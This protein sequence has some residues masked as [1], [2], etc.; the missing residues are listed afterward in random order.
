MSTIYSSSY[1]KALGQYQNLNESRIL[2]ERNNMQTSFD[3]LL[4]H[5]YLDKD[6]V[7]GLYREL[8]NMGFK[9]Y[10]LI[11]GKYKCC[12]KVY[13]PSQFLLFCAYHT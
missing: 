11:H 10:V 8:T 4:S 7:K 5:S 12:E 3:I 9:V 2:S 6:I 1:L 13:A